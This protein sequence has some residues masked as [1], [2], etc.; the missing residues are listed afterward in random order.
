MACTIGIPTKP[1]VACGE[2]TPEKHSIIIPAGARFKG[3]NLF[4]EY[5][6]GQKGALVFRNLYQI[7]DQMR[8]ALENG[9]V[10]VILK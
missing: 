8:Q 2:Q 6:N 5:P 4:W 3:G 7:P 1:A 9:P 10:E